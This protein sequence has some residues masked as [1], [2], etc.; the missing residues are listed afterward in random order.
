MLKAWFPKGKDNLNITLLKIWLHQG[1]YENQPGGKINS[2]FQMAK[3]ALTG[4]PNYS[5]RNKKFGGGL[6]S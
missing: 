2:L 3:G 4:E 5:Q 1:E 6:S